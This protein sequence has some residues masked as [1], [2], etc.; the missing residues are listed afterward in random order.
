MP[1]DQRR[2][3]RLIL[4]AET[5][6]SVPALKAAVGLGASIAMLA[7]AT[8]S[9]IRSTRS[10]PLLDEVGPMHLI[11]LAVTNPRLSR[12]ILDVE[13]PSTRHLRQAGMVTLVSTEESGPL[14]RQVSLR[15][16][17]ALVLRRR[18]EADDSGKSAQSCISALRQSV[19]VIDEV[20][21]EE[22]EEGVIDDAGAKHV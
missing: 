8:I 6:H 19:I 21:D 20:V 18:D 17:A 12:R 3:G 4:C 10:K 1:P 9:N 14:T 22:G 15:P 2:S 5:I 11:W 7:I 13:I 16:G